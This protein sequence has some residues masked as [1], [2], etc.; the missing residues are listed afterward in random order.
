MINSNMS[1][2]LKTKRIK[3]SPGIPGKSAIREVE[4]YMRDLVS[5]GVLKEGQQIVSEWELSRQ[6]GISRSSVHQALE[7]LT[8]EKV[9][10]RIPGKGTFVSSRSSN[11]N[12]LKGRKVA[13]ILPDKHLIDVGGGIY[14]FNSR[15]LFSGVVEE[16]GI[17]GADAHL[18]TC[19]P[20]FSPTEAEEWLQL[21]IHNNSFAGLIFENFSGYEALIE[22]SF[23]RNIPVALWNFRLEPYDTVT[24]DYRP[25]MY[26]AV[27]FLLKSGRNRII[28][29]GRTDNNHGGSTDKFDA[30]CK[31]IKDMG[32][33][34]REELVITIENHPHFGFKAVSRAVRSKL[35]FDAVVAVNDITAVDAVYALKENGIKIPEDVAVTGSDDMPGM[36]GFE[37]P[38]ATL[39]VPRVQV[40]RHLLQLIRNRIMEPGTP[41]VL[42]TLKAQFINRV[43]AGTKDALERCGEEAPGVETAI[44]M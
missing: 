12:G 10:Y 44:G 38:L 37:P 15:D 27:N 43:S 11:S 40:G 8:L 1:N 20:D 41:P 30:Y 29:L 14:W 13:F 22:K 19:K 16:A 18:Y 31:A 26:E 17:Y 3:N 24:V 32:M 2:M 33:P 34:L 5:R 35:K 6:F 23:Q 36:N 21:H 39:R 28:F 42:I 7:I 9:L 25:A 4:D